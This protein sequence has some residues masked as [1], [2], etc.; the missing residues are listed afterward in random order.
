MEIV[1]ALIAA[2]AGLAAGYIA[3]K[4]ATRFEYEKE[5][6]LAVAEVAK[7]IG[8][9]THSISWLTWRAKYQPE[10]LSIDH[11]DAFD[12]DMHRLYPELTGSLAVLAALNKRVYESVRSLVGRVYDLDDRVA[13]ATT[14]V[15][16]QVEGAASTLAEFHS[17]AQELDR[18]LRDGLGDIMD[19]V[20]KQKPLA[21]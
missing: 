6:R 17:Q 14:S 1:A 8:V 20:P 3:G 10:H 7:G 18:H 2:L 11:V 9:A 21:S 5:T 4:Q 16:D 19:L 15:R 13:Q 12:V